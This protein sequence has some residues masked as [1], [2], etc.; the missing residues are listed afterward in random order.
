[1]KQT[2]VEFLNEQIRLNSKFKENSKGGISFKIGLS[3][4]DELFKQAIEI[5]REQI[6]GTYHKGY[7][8]VLKVPQEEY[9]A[10]KYYNETYKNK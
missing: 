3:K 5:E 2:A 7:A 10:E 1:M 4:I 9:N 6:I 8:G